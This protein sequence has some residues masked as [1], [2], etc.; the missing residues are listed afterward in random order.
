MS[1]DRLWEQSRRREDMTPTAHL[2]GWM[3]YPDMAPA[4]WTLLDHQDDC[5]C[6][7]CVI[8]VPSAWLEPIERKKVTFA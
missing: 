1:I 2:A 5:E 7:S 6:C 4:Q 3:S 8:F